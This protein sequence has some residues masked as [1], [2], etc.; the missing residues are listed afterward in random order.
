[1]LRKQ[2]SKDKTNKEIKKNLPIRLPIELHKKLKI[3]AAKQGKTMVELVIEQF[4]ATLSLKKS[5]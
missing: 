3:Y 5:I 4:D 1:M 2:P